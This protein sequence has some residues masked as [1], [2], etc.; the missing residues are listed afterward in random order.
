VRFSAL[1][2]GEIRI[3]CKDGTYRWLMGN[4]RPVPAEGVM[5]GV[6]VDLTERKQLEEALA[7]RS[8]DL[9]EV[10]RELE[11]FSYSVSHDLRAPLGAIDGFARILVDKHGA[12]LSGEATRYL[13]LVR[14]NA[15]RMGRLIDDLLAFARLGASAA[16]AAAGGAG[17]ARGPSARRARRRARGSPRRDRRG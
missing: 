3:L 17:R 15:D 7:R 6:A 16:Q 8:A 9:E 13:Q 1:A 10:N 4:Y 2:S 5:Y 12:E 14:D 11:G